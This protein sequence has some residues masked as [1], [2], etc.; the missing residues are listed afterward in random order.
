MNE[1]LA[2][3]ASLQAMAARQPETWPPPGW[4]GAPGAPLPNEAQ[5][6]GYY[7]AHRDN[8]SPP[9]AW[10]DGLW[11]V[12]T[13]S[14]RAVATQPLRCE[15]GYTPSPGSSAKRAHASAEDRRRIGERVARQAGRP[16]AADPQQLTFGG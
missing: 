1:R 3:E 9:R 7:I 10:Q 13:H 5:A 6:W 4:E 12:L 15:P 2:Q 14:G 16:P 11:V 8:C